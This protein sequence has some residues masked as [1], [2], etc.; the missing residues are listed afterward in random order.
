MSEHPFAQ[1]VR[2]LGKGKKGSRPLTEDEAYSAMSMIL[3]R[4]T[5]PE[6]LGAFLMLMRIKEESSAELAGFVRAARDAIQNTS[7]TRP[8]VHLD[9]PSYS[10]KRRQLPWFILSALLLSENGINVL[11]HATNGP[12][13]EKMYTPDVL[14]QLGISA[15]ENLDEVDCALKQ[16]HFAFIPLENLS[17]ALKAILDLR[18]LLGL[19]SPVNTLLRLLNPLDAPYLIQGVFHPGYRDTHQGA[20]HHLKQT[21]LSVFKGEGGAAE[22]NPDGE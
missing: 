22:R 4:E 9:W 13:A 2:I 18:S 14:A 12:K 8:E 15:C 7:A 16:D 5:E 19:R 1:Y 10:G 11:M 3:A 6:Q 20:A 21:G 17:P